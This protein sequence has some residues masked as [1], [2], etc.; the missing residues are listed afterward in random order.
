M[1]KAN[2]DAEKGWQKPKEYLAGYPDFA[3]FISSDKELAIYRAFDTLSSRNI[4]YL[5]SELLFLQNKLEQFD[6][7]DLQSSNKADKMCAQSW[8]I[9]TGEGTAHNR[10]RLEVI[11]KIRTTLETYRRHPRAARLRQP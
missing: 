6:Q 8:E 5:Q 3:A 1:T 11:Q 7:H 4:L 2:A 9:L 10:E